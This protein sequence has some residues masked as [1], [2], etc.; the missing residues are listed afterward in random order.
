MISSPSSGQ[1]QYIWQGLLVTGD[2]TRHGKGAFSLLSP[3]LTAQI[4]AGI[5]VVLRSRL[6]PLIV[7]LDVVTELQP[8]SIR[9]VSV[10]EFYTECRET[11]SGYAA[12]PGSSIAAKIFLDSF[13]LVQ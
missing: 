10:L 7:N 1:R 12:F 4:Q 8:C 13:S 11:G 9:V 5:F 6:A 3:I 2:I